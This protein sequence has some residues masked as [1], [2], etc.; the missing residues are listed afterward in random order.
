MGRGQA[1]VDYLTSPFPSGVSPDEV[2]AFLSDPRRWDVCE[3]LHSIDFTMG[4][5]QFFMLGDNSAHS[6][7]GRLWGDQDR[8]EHYVSRELLTG[9]ALYL[10]WPHSFDEVNACGVRIPFPF[11]PNFA[12]MRFVR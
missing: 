9:R 3:H 5:G 11:F 6:K 10:Y 8:V 12:R 7:D 1:M 2:A 4:P